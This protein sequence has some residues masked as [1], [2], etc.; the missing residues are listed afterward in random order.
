MVYLL[1]SLVIGIVS[2]LI[3]SLVY[4]IAM[5]R[6]KPKLVV[7]ESM[8]Y[9]SD[10]NLYSVKVVNKTKVAL[11]NVFYSLQL[12]SRESRGV[13]NIE[14][15]KPAKDILHHFEKYSKDD[16]DESYAIRITFT[17][18]QK[19][20]LN[21]NSYLVFTIYATHSISGRTVYSQ[22]KYSKSKVV[23]NGFYET[24]LSTKVLTQ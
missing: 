21:T 17:D 16:L 15:I 24:G 19:L 2:G 4:F 22:L 9:S 12:H 18:E 20:K 10:D 8:T 7:A 14:H 13:V 5:R 6:V 1:Y 3:S 23:I 11:T